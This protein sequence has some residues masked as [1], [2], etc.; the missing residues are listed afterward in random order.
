L[1]WQPND[2]SQ[3]AYGVIYVVPVT[4]LPPGN[5]LFT[6]APQWAWQTGDTTQESPSVAIQNVPPG[7]A[8]F[9]NP[10]DVRDGIVYGPTGAEFLGTF[11]CAGGGA[12]TPRR[13]K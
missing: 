1:P 6:A 8:V 2:T 4:P 7:A 11:I 13:S 10:A 5:A 9:P 3:S 12:Y